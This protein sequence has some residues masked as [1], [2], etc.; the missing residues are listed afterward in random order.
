MGSSRMVGVHVWFFLWQNL[1]RGISVL[2]TG[3]FERQCYVSFSLSL[4]STPSLLQ[5]LRCSYAFDDA[6][7]FLFS[8][9]FFFRNHTFGNSTL[10]PP[11]LPDFLLLTVELTK[12]TGICCGGGG[13]GILCWWWLKNCC[14][15]WKMK[16]CAC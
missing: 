4:F 11:L 2:N 3:Y 8:F 5:A 12:V 7:S 1:T 16:V 13:G 6:S 10:C 9:L 14:G 15:G